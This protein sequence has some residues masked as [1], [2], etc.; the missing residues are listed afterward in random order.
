MA[1]VLI[2]A[3]RSNTIGAS[4]TQYDSPLDCSRISATTESQAHVTMRTAGTFSGLFCNISTN[5][6]GTSTLRFRVNS[7][8]GNQVV[9][10]TASTTGQF[11]D[12]TNSDT[13]AAGDEVNN[14]IVTGSGGST[15]TLLTCAYVFSATS[16]TTKKMG[17]AVLGAV[18]T[19]ST[20]F[21]CGLGGFVSTTSEAQT[22]LK[23]KTSGTFANLFANIVTNGRSTTSTLRFRKNT[24]DGNQVISVTAGSTGLFEDTSNTDTVAVD[25]LV[26]LVIVLGT[27]TGNLLLHAFASELTATNTFH[28][29]AGNNSG[30]ALLAAAT[31]AYPAAGRLE[32]TMAETNYRCDAQFPFTLSKLSCYVTANTIVED[33]LL[34]CRVNGGNGN[35]VA[36]VTGLTTGLFEDTTNSDILVATDEINL[37]CV[38]GATGTSLTFT[39][40]SMLGTVTSTR[41]LLALMGCGPFS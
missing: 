35:Q 31:D 32:A 29:V 26:N 20:S 12:T 23:L 39:L 40:M 9:T 24:A 41:H 15:F 4:A 22:Q 13:V 16:G 30:I 8:N 38:A 5:N 11:E 37:R 34:R 14:Q 33:S 6:R 1:K 27:G 18:S 19:A 17:T 2:I 25:D 21:Y 28:L 36:T 10:I 7:A 3:T